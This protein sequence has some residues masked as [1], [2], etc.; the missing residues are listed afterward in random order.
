[1][2][3]EDGQF[4]G[5]SDD[6]ENRRKGPRPE[7]NKVEKRKEKR[8]QKLIRREA[9]AIWPPATERTKKKGGRE[10]RATGQGGQ[11]ERHDDMTTWSLPTNRTGRG[12]YGIGPGNRQT[13][14]GWE[15]GLRGA[16]D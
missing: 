5:D 9:G 15:Y 14:D 13:T 4:Q 6:V 16:G 10:R 3:G 8:I 12:E 2:G 1:M 11:A 7:K